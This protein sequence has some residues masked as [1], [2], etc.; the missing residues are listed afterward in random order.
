[1]TWR[2]CLY[3]SKKDLCVN[4]FVGNLAYSATEDDVRQ[5]FAAYGEVD[6][7][8]LVTDQYTGRARGFGFVEMPKSH[9]AQ[10]AIEGLQGKSL[11]GRTLTVNEAKPRAPR[12]EPS[13]S[14]W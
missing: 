5:L 3:L 11:G 7:V 4:I 9:E 10:T 12:R 8:R 13:P 1:M 6:T 2:L 14:R